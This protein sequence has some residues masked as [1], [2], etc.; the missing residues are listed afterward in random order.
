[1]VT[2]FVTIFG[3]TSRVTSES[4]STFRKTFL[5]PST[6]NEVVFNDFSRGSAVEGGVAWLVLR[7]AYGLDDLEFESRQR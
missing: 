4:N 3:T 1:M 7:L 2:E 6:G 5:C